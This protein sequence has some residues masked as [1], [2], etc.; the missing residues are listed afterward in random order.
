M[1]SNLEFDW[2]IDSQLMAK[3]DNIRRDPARDIGEYYHK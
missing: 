2:I 1:L 3:K